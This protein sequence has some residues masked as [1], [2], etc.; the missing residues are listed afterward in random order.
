MEAILLHLFCERSIESLTTKVLQLTT[1]EAIEA[2][3]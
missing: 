3:L 1:K 2:N